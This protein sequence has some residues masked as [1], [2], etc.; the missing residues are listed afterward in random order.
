MLIHHSVYI[1]AIHHTPIKYNSNFYITPPG[2][3]ETAPSQ[4]ID[5]LKVTF[6]CLSVGIAGDFESGV[7]RMSFSVVHVHADTQMACKQEMRG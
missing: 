2:T 6:F 4:C 3:N 5:D 7:D 1:I